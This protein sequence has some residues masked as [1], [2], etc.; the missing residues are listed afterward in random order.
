MGVGKRLQGTKA[1][2][3]QL[4]PSPVKCLLLRFVLLLTLELQ[5]QSAD[6]MNIPR[7]PRRGDRPAD[8]E[9]EPL[10]PD[11]WIAEHRHARLPSNR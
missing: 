11:R 2:E 5:D 9:L 6:G 3:D 8:R 7:L 1:N 4:N 10:L